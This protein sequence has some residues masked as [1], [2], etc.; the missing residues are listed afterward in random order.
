M[1]LSDEN[2]IMLMAS[3]AFVVLC[4]LSMGI[5][6]YIRKKRY[7]RSVIKK[8]Q[9]TDDDWSAIENHNESLDISGANKSK[10]FFL[11]ILSMIG[12][13]TNPNRSGE[14]ADI[15]IKFLRA[16]LRG[17][18]IPTI[19]WGVKFLLAIGL[20][21]SFII[22]AFLFFPDMKNQAVLWIAIFLSL[23]GLY[24]PDLWLKL[25][26]SKRKDKI[27]KGFPDALDLLVVCVEA[28]MGLDGAINRVGKELELNQ[29]ELSEEFNALNLELRAGK[30]RPT[31]LKNL[32]KRTD[33]DDV[34]SLVT[35]LLQT[36]RFGTSV[37]KALR[38]FS[39]SFRTARYQRA[40]EA[41]AKMATKLLFPLAVC[42]FPAMFVV[43]LGPICITIYRVMINPS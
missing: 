28:G 30:A 32:A 12:L 43:I 6:I 5:L 29:P 42:I 19:F 39:D 31:A 34:N 26:T 14:E 36:D 24:L 13:K 8:I 41:A 17:K 37:A 20:P 11:N 22:S 18:N 1:I 15:K 25:K 2:I 33:I 10:N 21:V 35:V 3:L 27:T 16:G 23:L 4:L 40:E 9:A 38:V 7:Q